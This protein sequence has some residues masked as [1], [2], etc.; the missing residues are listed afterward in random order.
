MLDIAELGQVGIL[1][2]IRQFAFLNEILRF[3]D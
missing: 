2:I 3:V 1:E